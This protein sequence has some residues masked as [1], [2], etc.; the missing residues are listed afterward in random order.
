MTR[1]ASTHD[2]HKNRFA[3]PAVE[4]LETRDCPATITLN[5]YVITQNN[6]AFS[7]Q[8]SDYQNAPMQILFNGAVSG[9]TETFS[10]G[11]FYFI[12]INMQPGTVTA[13]GIENGIEVTDTASLQV[14]ST[15]PRVFIDSV[16]NEWTEFYMITGHVTDEDPAGLIVRLGGIPGTYTAEVNSDG[17][18]TLMCMISEQDAQN[19]VLT[20]TTTDWWGIESNTARWYLL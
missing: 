13:V 4:R 20:A 2:S 16:T 19:A 9:M 15:A 11:S 8:V 3:R 1:C 14:S 5:S 10:D 6:V 17:T 18:F 7:G 12:G